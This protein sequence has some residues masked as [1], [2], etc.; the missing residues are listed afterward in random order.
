MHV[1]GFPPI[2]R[3]DARILILGSMPGVRSI[4]LNQ[5]YGHPRNA[6]W[7]IMG[8]VY[9]FDPASPY[10]TRINLLQNARLAVWDVLKQCVRPGS[11]DSAI[12]HQGMVPNGFADFFATHTGIERV[13]F[14]G[15]QSA[16]LFRRYV[17]P[18]LVIQSKCEWC[19]LPST[20]PAHA[21]M[22]FEKKL[23]LWRASL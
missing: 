3:S 2:A 11:L 6:F 13:C 18:S 5:Y 9:G 22:S 15:A 7:R 12:Q 20:S 21:A 10:E 17:L 19:A 14:N 23:A 4:E 1:E 8:E 16:A